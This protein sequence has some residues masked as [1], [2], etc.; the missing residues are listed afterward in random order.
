MAKRYR[1]SGV[2]TSLLVLVPIW[3]LAIAF[4]FL[5]SECGSD[6][7]S[8]VA[9]PRRQAYP[10]IELYDT[11]YRAVDNLPVV[12]EVNDCATISRASRDGMENPNW[13]NVKYS[14]YGATLHCTYTS[15]ADVSISEVM[16]NRIERMSLN[17]GELTTDITT[18]STSQGVTATVLMTPMAKVTPIQFLATDSA[19]Y[20]MTGALYLDNASVATDS[21][22]PILD[23]VRADVIHAVT[24]LRKR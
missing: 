7:H 6:G 16:N 21:V 17:T 19:T 8:E 11:V 12:F 15:V 10:R 13:I 22:M 23:A 3:T 20:V 24:H 5:M 1:E 14:R 18:L 9:V 4:S 2:K